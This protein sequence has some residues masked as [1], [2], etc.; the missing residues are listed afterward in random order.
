[1]SLKNQIDKI[2][3]LMDSKLETV[4]T[5]KNEDECV[6]VREIIVNNNYNVQVAVGKCWKYPANF[7][8]V[9]HV[10]EESSGI[11]DES[12]I[13]IDIKNRPKSEFIQCGV[14]N[15]G[16]VE[17]CDMAKLGFTDD[18]KWGTLENLME[19]LEKL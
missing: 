15:K 12:T 2:K 9:G 13:K 1:M 16:L 3:E 10:Y 4:E 7:S 14:A 6:L 8:I 11:F 17:T 19:I 5:P 18:Q